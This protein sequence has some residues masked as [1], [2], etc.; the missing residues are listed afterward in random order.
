MNIEQLRKPTIRFSCENLKVYNY[1][2]PQI[3]YGIIRPY[4]KT[5]LAQ[6]LDVWLQLHSVTR[7]FVKSRTTFPQKEQSLLRIVKHYKSYLIS[8]VLLTRELCKILPT[9]MYQ[10]ITIFIFFFQPHAL[11]IP[12]TSFKISPS[13]NY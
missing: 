10:Y 3:E 12:H 5:T 7:L 11:F 6:L 13:N 1:E 4:V 8:R 9:K 2:I